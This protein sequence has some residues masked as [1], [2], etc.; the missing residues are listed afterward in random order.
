MVILRRRIE[1]AY[2]VLFKQVQKRLSSSEMV[3]KYIVGKTVHFPLCEQK[4]RSTQESAQE[5]NSARK[6]KAFSNKISCPL[7]CDFKTLR[8]IVTRKNVQEIESVTLQ[9]FGSRVY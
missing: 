6:S 5:N 8:A 3:L 1:L 2:R 4:S 9:D 7:E